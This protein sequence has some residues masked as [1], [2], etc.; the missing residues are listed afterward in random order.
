MNLK[1]RFPRT[2]VLFGLCS[3]LAVFASAAVEEAVSPVVTSVRVYPDP[4]RADLHS[5]LLITFDH[6][7]LHSTIKIFTVAGRLVRTLDADSGS[8]TWDRKNDSGDR[9][10][11]GVYLYLLTDGQGNETKGKLAIIN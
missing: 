6:M 3:G 5:N 4:W 7:A 8:A 11:S 1:S 9:V 2:L 10:A